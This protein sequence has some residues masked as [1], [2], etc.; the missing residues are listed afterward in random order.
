MSDDSGLVDDVRSSND[1]QELPIK[2]PTSDTNSPSSIIPTC[3]QSCIP[4]VHTMR[5]SSNVRLPS[6]GKEH[7][8]DPLDI[9]EPLKSVFSAKCSLQQPTL[10]CG[11][12]NFEVSAGETDTSGEL[13]SKTHDSSGGDSLSASNPVPGEVISANSVQLKPCNDPDCSSLNSHTMCCQH[14]SELST[15]VTSRN[16]VINRKDRVRIQLQLP[17]DIIGRF[18]GK[19]GR[20][21]KALM[22][23]SD[24]AHV[25][26]NQKNVPKDTP[27]VPCTVQGTAKQVDE[28]IAIIESKYPEVIIPGTLVNGSPME[29]FQQT[30][31]IPTPLFGTSSKYECLESWDFQ[32]SMASIPP[33]PFSACVTYL[34]SLRYIWVVACERSMELEDQHQSM[35]FAYCY[36]GVINHNLHLV[37]KGNPEL[38]G[39]F[40]AV[41]VSEIHWLRGRISKFGDDQSSYEVQLVDYGSDVVVPQS[42]IKP[43]R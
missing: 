24:G 9:K 10:C 43:L 40:C 27:F 38:L 13:S 6:C 20:N 37:D 39:K 32:L 8:D 2:Q 26:I 3:V 25:Y 17:R 14:N 21:I 28:A 23:D 15:A 19:Q 4:C 36:S 42:A 18:I 41:R 11:E 31:S 22:V 7:S 34:E 12:I 29:Q 1:K 35:S 5:T 30:T 33:N 16:T